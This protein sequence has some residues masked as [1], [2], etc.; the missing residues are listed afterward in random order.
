MM[1]TYEPAFRFLRLWRHAA[2]YVMGV[3]VEHTDSRTVKGYRASHAAAVFSP[4]QLAPPHTHTPSHTPLP[5]P[6]AL[7]TAAL[8][9][10]ALTSAALTTA[11]LTTAAALHLAHLD[12]PSQP[13]DDEDEQ[14]GQR[15]ADIGLATVPRDAAATE[16]LAGLA[17]GH[18]GG[19][20]W[21][22]AATA[23]AAAAPAAAMADGGTHVRCMPPSHG[24]AG[25]G[26]RRCM[27]RRRRMARCWPSQVHCMARHWAWVHRTPRG[28]RHVGSATR[29]PA[30]A[31]AAAAAAARQTPRRHSAAARTARVSYRDMHGFARFSDQDER[32]PGALT[33][34]EQTAVRRRARGRPR[35]TQGVA[36]APGRGAVAA[37]AAVAAAFAAG[38][39]AAACCRRCCCAGSC[40]KQP[41]RHISRP[42]GTGTGALVCVGH[43]GN[44][45]ISHLSGREAPTANLSLT[46]RSVS[47]SQVLGVPRRQS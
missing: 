32:A 23:A 39:A 37:A 46:S 35:V 25:G 26:R 3:C 28:H 38:S 24:W 42:E 27:A 4:P 8:T 22:A 12:L 5:R 6:A 15:V 19:G 36:V 29:S 44:D 21:G 45:Y 18:P 34:R 10:A 1:C 43:P 33:K 30:V 9:S 16:R 7:T 47:P 40:G 41:A 11:A 2:S 20:S 31:A 13:H 17:D 14:A